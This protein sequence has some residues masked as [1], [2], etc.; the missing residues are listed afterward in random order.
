[1]SRHSRIRPGSREDC[2]V[3]RDPILVIG[4]LVQIEVYPAQGNVDAVQDLNV[5]H[6]TRSDFALVTEEKRRFEGPAVAAI[7]FAR[8]ADCS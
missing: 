2:D 8:L 6:N 7:P 4:E 1:M 3:P 5:E